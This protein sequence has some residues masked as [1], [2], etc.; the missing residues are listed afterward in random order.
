MTTRILCGALTCA[1][2]LGCAPGNDDT[3]DDTDGGPADAA[4]ADAAPPRDDVDA[5]R[6]QTLTFPDARAVDLLFVIDDSSS[7]CQEQDNLTANFRVIA[8][9]LIADDIDY[10]IAVTNTDFSGRQAPGGQ[11]L[12]A[13][14]APVASLVCDVVPNTADCE[15]LVDSGELTAILGPEPDRDRLEQKFRCLAT[16]G[17][18]GSPAEA[19]L[20]A[21]RAALSCDGPNAERF[22]A[23]CDGDTYDPTCTADVEFLRPAAALAIVILSDEDDCSHGETAPAD[24]P[25]ALCR[26][27]GQRD[28]DGDGVPDIYAELC[29]DDAAGCLERDCGERDLD[30]C[31]AERC[32]LD[33]AEDAPCL[34]RGEDLIPVERYIDAVAALKRD[35]RQISVTPLTGPPDTLPDGTPRTWAPADSAECAEPPRS[36]DGADAYLA[37]CCVDA[38]CRGTTPPLCESA[39]GHALGGT[40]YHTFQAAFPPAA[41]PAPTLCADDLA[42]QLEIVARR[43]VDSLAT[44]CL[45]ADTPDPRALT[46]VLECTAETCDQILPPTVL[47]ADDY[48]L[49]AA[50]P[51][52]DDRPSLTLDR[53][54]PRAARLTLT[55]PAVLRGDTDTDDGPCPLP[56]ACTGD[57]PA[58]GA[59][60]GGV[61]TA[62]WSCTAREATS[63]ADPDA[64][65][66]GLDAP[67]P[68]CATRQGSAPACALP[69]QS[70]DTCDGDARCTPLVPDPFDAPC[71]D[72]ACRCVEPTP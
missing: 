48:R 46:A 18:I 52:C 53:L 70:D 28:D 66:A 4:P 24:H 12:V 7:M 43:L 1:L 26:P 16:L 44:V 15:A 20:A 57:T 29:P 58:A 37:A 25:A 27:D 64:P 2:A 5:I 8:D 38:A 47:D 68:V 62:R 60:V 14:T 22:A 11:F 34:H 41:D 63:C 6:H 45:D 30:T 31:V 21:L 33:F 49:I 67:A 3:P 59:P 54:P 51:R 23:C 61:S 9:R 39:N 72:G 65:D 10:R 71:D 13:P 36:A 17:T 40:R 69:C 50:D 19:G 42:P 55:Y 56:A 35:P 32:T